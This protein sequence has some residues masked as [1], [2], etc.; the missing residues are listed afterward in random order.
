MRAATPRSPGNLPAGIPAPHKT[1]TIDDDGRVLV[2]SRHLALGYLDPAADA[3]RFIRDADGLTTFR[4][5]D[6]G[7]WEG[8]GLIL[9]GRMDDAVK[10]R[11]YLVEP[12]EIREALLRSGDLADAAVITRVSDSGAT[13]L[14]AYVVPD[15]RVRTPP[16]SVIRARLRA[17]LPSLDGARPHRGVD[18]APPYRARQT[19]PGCAARPSGAPAAT[20]VDA[21]ESALA[22]VWASALRLDSVGR[23]EN[24]YALG[25]DSLTVAQIL[26]DVTRSTGV[27]LTEA[28][29]AAA[30]TVA[31][32]AA[33]IESRRVR[34]QRA[35]LSPTTVRLHDGAKLRGGEGVPV[36]CFT[37]AGASALTFVPF[38]HQMA[39]T[40][41]IGAIHAF[42]PNGL[43]NRGLPDWTVAAAARRHLRDL[44][45][46]APHGPYVL[47]GHSLGGFIALEAARRLRADGG[48]VRLVV[49]VDTFVPAR[50]RGEVRRT[51]PAVSMTPERPPLPRRELWRRRLLVPFA[52]LYRSPARAAQAME[53][54]GVRVG[55]LHRPKPYDGPVLLVQGSDNVDD[56]HFWETT[57]ARGEFTVAR[58]DSDHVSIV[59]EPHINEVVSLIR[60]HLHPL[61]G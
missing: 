16:T 32:M 3:G 12:S 34:A 1:I 57:I 9:H 49:A 42:T 2:S 45:R 24:V 48:D 25:A 47:V 39:G 13:E 8:P 58:V 36:F 35:R 38:A 20:P 22:E 17:S 44:R 19:R 33:T 30:P 51:D 52:G 29:A 23:N 15:G 43:D 4:T 7:A 21:L 56:P 46:I 40:A 5:G 10:V 60:D 26:A 55:R 27:R 14:V 59:R 53:E 61:A 6:R 54:I 31:E 11:G 41:G 18:R 50:I 37:G 28:E